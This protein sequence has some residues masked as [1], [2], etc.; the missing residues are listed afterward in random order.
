MEFTAPPPQRC[1]DGS[2]VLLFRFQVCEV[3]TPDLMECPSPAVPRLSGA[4]QTESELLRLGESRAARM[5]RSPDTQLSE[6][7][8]QQELQ[9]SHQGLRECTASFSSC[10]LLW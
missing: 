2:P 10:R 6:Q 1:I 7:P 9:V 3:L 5:Y 8:P 4:G